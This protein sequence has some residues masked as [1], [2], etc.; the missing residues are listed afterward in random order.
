MLTYHQVM[1]TDLDLLTKAADKWEA[2]AKDFETIQKT[3]DG[4]VRKVAGDGSWTGIAAGQFLTTTSAQTSKQYTSAATEAR[5]IA[6]LLRDAHREFTE[7]R[8]CIKSAVAD[9]AEKH[10]KIDDNGVAKSTQQFDSAARHD[11]DY[12]TELNKIAEAEQ[13]WT[14]HIATL[15][16]AADDADQ[17]MQQA[18]QAA[19]QD[20]DFSDG[21]A[22]GFNSRAEGDIGKFE[23]K[24]ATELTEEL[25]SKG[26]DEKKLAELERLFSENSENRAFS[27]TLLDNIGADGTIKLSHKLDALTSSD[28]GHKQDYMALQAGLATSVSSATADPKSPF[29]NKWREELRKAGTKNF[30]SK[31]DPVYGYQSFV[32]LMEHHDKYGKRFLND[33]GDDIIAAEKK[34]KDIWTKWRDHPG[35]ASDPL[36]HLLGIMGKNPDAA[37][38]FLDPGS[39]GKNEN[40][41]Y[42]MKERSW[43]KIALNGPGALM[44]RDDPTSRTGLGMA[45]EAATTG[46]TPISEGQRP[47]PDARHNESQAR[48]MHNTIEFLDQGTSTEV[49]S[50]LRKPVA[51]ALAEY[52]ADTHEILGGASPDSIKNARQGY[53]SDADSSRKVHMST[54]REHLIHVLRGVS[55]DADAYGTLHRAETEYIAK[56]LDKLPGNATPDNVGSVLGKTGAALGTYS[57]IREDISND[58]RSQAYTNADWKTKVAYHIIGGA[59]TPLTIGPKNFPIGDAAQR[60]VD[61]WAFSMANDMKAQADAKA[62][63][64][65][66]DHYLNASNQMTLM[67]DEW[68]KTHG[69]NT[70]AE[71]GKKRAESLTFQLMSDFTTGNNFASKMLTDTTN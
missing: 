4:Q 24:R 16:Q 40:L 43:P 30:G 28:K 32:G 26:L 21:F 1:T 27:Q 53:W 20:T 11:P 64:A 33:L 57:A 69:I 12:R 18:L 48:V 35:T 25:T 3:Y 7:A 37:T 13:A 71:E 34:D 49:P 44:S 51:N 63:A 31:T 47:E 68:A 6:S 66:S 56:E 61:T 65:I 10:I 41:K 46:H 19:V 62:N 15:V 55:E 36:D 14:Q 45:I 59:V 58:Q 38:S 42:L 54:S 2:A 39:E 50:N 60:I 5:A 67:M 22:N 9:A 8:G 17:G 29:Y 70:G 52:T 23:A